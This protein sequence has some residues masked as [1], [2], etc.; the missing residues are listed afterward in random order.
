MS[1]QN[2]NI[3]ITI[4]SVSS[5]LKPL[6]SHESVSLLKYVIK[7]FI[8]STTFTIIIVYRIF[9]KFQ[10]FIDIFFADA[11]SIL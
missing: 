10:N 4:Q 5:C 6:E 11:L 1:S 8:L 9:D 3:D 2:C 7:S